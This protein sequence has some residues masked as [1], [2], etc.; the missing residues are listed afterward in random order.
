MVASCSAMNFPNSAAGLQR[1]PNG[2]AFMKS[3]YSLVLTTLASAFSRVATIAAGVPLGA[4]MP[5]H[6]PI[7]QLIPSSLSVGTSLNAGSR[8]SAMWASGRTLPASM[9]GRPSTRLAV[10]TWTPPATSS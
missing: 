2:P 1:M 4:A 3:L 5:R 7:V 6:A 9:R 8:L 10:T